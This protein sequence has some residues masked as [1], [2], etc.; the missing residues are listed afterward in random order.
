MIVTQTKVR[1]KNLID[2]PLSHLNLLTE[3]V[4]QPIDQSPLKIDSLQTT[5]T[6]HNMYL[7]IQIHLKVPI[8]AL[9]NPLLLQT[10]MMMNS[11]DTEV[12]SRQVVVMALVRQIMEVRVHHMIVVRVPLIKDSVHQVAVELVHQV[13]VIPTH[14]VV[15]VVD[16][17]QFG[18]C[19]HPYPLLM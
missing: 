19:P 8:K 16:T 12:I 6:P 10:H 11:E 17:L 14:R 15:V 2:A 13:V 3:P 9:R 4:R 1:R 18:T 7:D 5:E